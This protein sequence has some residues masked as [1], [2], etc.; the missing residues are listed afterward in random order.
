MCHTRVSDVCVCV[1]ALEMCAATL[2]PRHLLPPPTQVRVYEKARDDYAQRFN[3]EGLPEACVADMLRGRAVCEAGGQ[4]LALQELLGE[5]FEIRVE[6]EGD[7]VREVET[8]GELVTLELVRTKNKC[9]SKTVGALD[10]TPMWIR[11]T[12]HTDEKSPSHTGPYVA[13]R[14]NDMCG[15]R[16]SDPTHFRNFLNNLRMVR[17]VPGNMVATK[18]AFVELQVHHVR[19]YAHNENAHAHGPYEYF[20]RILGG[21]YGPELNALL[22]R[23]IVF[24][25]EVF[26]TPVLLSMLI[27]CLTHRDEGS[28]LP[29]SLM[30]LYSTAVR[31]ALRTATQD[32]AAALT[33][34]IGVMQ[35]IA[36]ANMVA[37]GGMRREFT[38]DDLREALGD[39][40]VAVWEGLTAVDGSVPL[41]KTLEQKT[42]ST[43]AIYQFR[44]LSFQE[45][46]FASQL[47]RGGAATWA[48][49]QDDY[50]AA[51]SLKEPSLRNAL[52]IGGGALGS[53][54][55]RERNKW[56]FT[57]KELGKGD[58]AALRALTGLLVNNV[59][60]REL[61]CAKH[62]PLQSAT[63]RSSG[64]LSRVW[65][66][67]SNSLLLTAS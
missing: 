61:K 8:G 32:N 33:E 63:L 28:R 22:E 23:V 58:Q 16:F 1:F 14:W 43:P 40:G 65:L 19:V 31:G 26:H 42:V 62:C 4:Q 57:K 10:D 30:E 53:A 7:A 44:H 56:D 50:A 51:N 24:M 36:T 37:Q 12:L 52:R 15:C 2:C 55:G 6:G 11:T 17:C 47:I 5:S 27:L 20:R 39:E 45:A 13:E 60:L 29:A 38:S 59:T 66:L 35:H 41:V 25:E 54:L 64:V 34:A 21:S 67:Q 49:W 3:D 46:L 48:G 9:S 18:V